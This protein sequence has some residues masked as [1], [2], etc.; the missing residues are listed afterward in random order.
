M[1]RFSTIEKSAELLH[2]IVLMYKGTVDIGQVGQY[3]GHVSNSYSEHV[4]NSY[5]GQV[6]N[7]YS[8]DMSPTVTVKTCL[9]LLK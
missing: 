7:C 1:C 8:G 4:S 5:S 2:P 9:Q 6:S 3:S